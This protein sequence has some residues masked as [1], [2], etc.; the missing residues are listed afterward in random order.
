M[1]RSKEMEMSKKARQQEK[2]NEAVTPFID[3]TTQ[4]L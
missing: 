3:R 1:C 2:H 4:A